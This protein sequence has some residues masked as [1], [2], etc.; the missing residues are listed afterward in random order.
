M[1]RV[2]LCASDG[3]KTTEW[4]QLPTA[5][6]NAL[7]VGNSS[8]LACMQQQSKFLRFWAFCCYLPPFVFLRQ[9]PSLPPSFG[10]Y[11]VVWMGNKKRKG[12]FDLIYSSGE[13]V[14][15]TGPNNPSPTCRKAFNASLASAGEKH[16]LVICFLKNVKVLW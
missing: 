1:S 12:P 16:T 5:P 13:T 3:S 11:L 14:C 9:C 10:L 2:R 6:S 7:E 8:T 4:N 15:S